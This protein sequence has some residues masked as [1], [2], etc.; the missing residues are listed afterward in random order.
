MVGESD[1]IQSEWDNALASVNAYTPVAPAST[2]A[3]AAA[4]SVD[5]VVATSSMS[6]T[7]LPFVNFASAQNAPSTFLFLSAAVRPTCESVCFFRISKCDE[8]PNLI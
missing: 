1:I 2:R 7:D 5:P 3:A 6:R 8:Y 4:E